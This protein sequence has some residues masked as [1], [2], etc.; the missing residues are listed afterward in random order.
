VDYLN[1]LFPSDIDLALYSEGTKTEPNF[2][3]INGV[4]KP[5]LV[6]SDS[7]LG[8]VALQMVY[9]DVSGD[10]VDDLIVHIPAEVFV[11]IWQ[12]DHYALP[13]RKAKEEMS[14][15]G[16]SS[17]IS[18]YDWTQDGTLEINLDDDDTSVHGTGILGTNTTRYIIHCQSDGCNLAWK[19]IRNK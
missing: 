16:P 7:I 8:T 3:S 15:A 5:A 13:Y 11:F 9:Q 14:W 17:V 19:G 4:A 1:Q 6:I 12:G 18:F 10:K 2:E